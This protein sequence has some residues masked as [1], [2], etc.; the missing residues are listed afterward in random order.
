[1]RIATIAYFSSFGEACYLV[2]EFLGCSGAPSGV[3]ADPGEHRS[4]R[5]AGLLKTPGI[6][7][8]TPRG[9]RIRAGPL[10]PPPERSC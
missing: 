6:P 4:L 2:S 5:F 10:P 3:V 1:M 7:Y 8:S 9:A